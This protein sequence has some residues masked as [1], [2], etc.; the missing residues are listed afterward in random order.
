MISLSVRMIGHISGFVSFKITSS[1]SFF[2]LLPRIHWGRN[3]G[4]TLHTCQHITHMMLLLHACTALHYFSLLRCTVLHCFVPVVPFC[5]IY[6]VLCL[7]LACFAGTGDCLYR[8]KT[9][10]DLHKIKVFLGL[11]SIV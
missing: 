10:A 7:L 2:V 8:C 3:I 5:Y 4:S 11:Q 1:I 6:V 9:A